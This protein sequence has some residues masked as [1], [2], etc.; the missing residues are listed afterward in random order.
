ML[1]QRT[2]FAD[3]SIFAVVYRS[4]VEDVKPLEDSV[5][6]AAGIRIL[7][8]GWKHPRSKAFVLTL[9]VQ[10]QTHKQRFAFCFL[11]LT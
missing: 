7:P 11:G 10:P 8:A 9:G 2:K 6:E 3:L 5:S 1:R 4:S